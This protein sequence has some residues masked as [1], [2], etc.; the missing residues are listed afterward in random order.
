MNQDGNRS[1]NLEPHRSPRT[2]RL[3][4]RRVRL[5]RRSERHRVLRRRH[6]SHQP[7][8]AAQHVP[9]VR[10]PDDTGHLLRYPSAGISDAFGG[11]DRLPRRTARRQSRSGRRQLHHPPRHRDAIEQRDAGSLR[12][13]SRPSRSLRRHP[14]RDTHRRDRRRREHWHHV[15]PAIALRIPSEDGRAGGC[16]SRRE[17]AAHIGHRRIRQLLVAGPPVHVLRSP[18]GDVGGRNSGATGSP[19]HRT[20]GARHPGDDR[21]RDGA[22]RRR[23]DAFVL[24]RKRPRLNRKSRRYLARRGRSSTAVQS[25][26]S[27]DHDRNHRR[28]GRGLRR[29]ASRD[30]PRPICCAVSAA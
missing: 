3:L 16:V 22:G 4:Q 14:H 18:V 19:G 28:D 12:P 27:R 25:S 23:T 5:R 17:R 2:A 8:R 29:L 21:L 10:R 26:R 24:A 15:C 11:P 20:P 6:H 7:E 9:S 1:R 13:L 30:F